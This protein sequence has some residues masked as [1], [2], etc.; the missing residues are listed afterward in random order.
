MIKKISFSLLLLM[1]LGGGV[2]GYYYFKPVANFEHQ[3]P[4][5]KVPAVQLISEYSINEEEANKKYLNKLVEVSGTVH[6]IMEDE[7][8]IININLAVENQVSMVTCCMD[9]TTN[10]DYSMLSKGDHVQI[11]GLC[12]GMLMDIVQVRCVLVK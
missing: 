8:G 5:I 2:A 1:S 4:D 9:S 11:K 12:S 10:N 7:K 3:K 6:D